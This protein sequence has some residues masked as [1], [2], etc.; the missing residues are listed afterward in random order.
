MCF[1]SACAQ[2]SEG[3]V[4]THRRSEPNGGSFLK[5]F[6]DN[7]FNDFIF[8]LQNEREYALMFNFGKQISCFNKIKIKIYFFRS[9][10]L[11]FSIS[12]NPFSLYISFM[13]ICKQDSKL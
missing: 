3:L 4:P 11:F 10:A 9:R 6:V 8:T 13:F 5:D 7:I 12:L 2:A 1:Q